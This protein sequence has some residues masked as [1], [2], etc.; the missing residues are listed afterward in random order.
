MKSVQNFSTKDLV[1][2]GVCVCLP[3][4]HAKQ[5]TQLCRISPHGESRQ[6]L[7]SP[8]CIFSSKRP[9]TP[10]LTGSSEIKGMKDR[11][12]PAPEPMYHRT[13]KRQ[14]SWRVVPLYAS[15]RTQC[16]PAF[17]TDPGPCLPLL[18]RWEA[19]TATSPDT[20]WMLI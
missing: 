9:V 11:H 2:N 20:L 19:V 10:E 4:G 13:K 17:H 16:L 6:T 15:P 1:C 7:A 5:V 14:A 18:Y 8:A 12:R 3:E